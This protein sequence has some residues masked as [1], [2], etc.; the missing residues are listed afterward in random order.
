MEF[1]TWMGWGITLTMIALAVVLGGGN[2]AT[3]WDSASVL[4]VFGGTLGA[5][6]M[7]LPLAQLRKAPAIL[8]KLMF[9]PAPKLPEIVETLVNLAELARREG[10]LALEP[11]SDE[12]DDPFLRKGVR[13]MVDGNKPEV[14]E[15]ILR[16]D[17]DSMRLR[18]REGKM[19]F[20]QAGRFAPAFGMIGTLL[21]LITMLGQLSDPTRI[22]GGMAVALITTLYGVVL[23]NASFL[24]L[25]D[26]LA[27]L[28]RRE[29]IAREV[30]LRGVLAIQSGEGPRL[31]AYKLGTFLEPSARTREL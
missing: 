3:F 26:K 22:G 6:C 4:T 29:A 8:R 17:I 23:S 19:I 25:A 10:L 18:H 13:L 28:S 12:I 15:E 20:D 16:A 2:F 27:L 30:V 1:G 11:R 7:C 24:P 21:G 31:I 5:L 14:I 9:S